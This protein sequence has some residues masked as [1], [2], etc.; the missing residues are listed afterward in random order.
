MVDVGISVAGCVEVEGWVAVGVSV[1]VAVST[2]SNVPSGAIFRNEKNAM[3][4]TIMM[5]TARIPTAPGKL[6]VI[7]GMRLA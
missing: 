6:K 3:N 7:A 1:G 5:T 4:A 2:E